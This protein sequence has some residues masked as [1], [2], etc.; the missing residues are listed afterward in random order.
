M[1]L[2]FNSREQILAFSLFTFKFYILQMN[3]EKECSQ[4]LDAE[5][6]KK[7]RISDDLK[8]IK[9]QIKN[10]INEIKI[11]IQRKESVI[12]ERVRSIF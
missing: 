12:E 4:T 9:N 5:F 1:V 3:Y 7:K 6:A 8:Q 2:R 10:Q 11:D